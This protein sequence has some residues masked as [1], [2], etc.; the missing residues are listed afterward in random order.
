MKV[1]LYNVFYFSFLVGFG[2]QWKIAY[3]S[4]APWQCRRFVHCRILNNLTMKYIFLKKLKST[5]F[6]GLN[7]C[8]H[9]KHDSPL[10]LV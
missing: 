6:T 5:V 1:R 10:C 4:G 2:T 3:Y 9:N 7:D 8:S